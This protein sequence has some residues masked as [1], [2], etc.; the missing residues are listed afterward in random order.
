MHISFVIQFTPKLIVSS[1]SKTKIR[2]PDESR[3][4]DFPHAYWLKA[5]VPASAGMTEESVNPIVA[6]VG[7]REKMLALSDL[8]PL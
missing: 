6:L 2:H 7:A 4:P 5:W 1:E 3:D 8:I